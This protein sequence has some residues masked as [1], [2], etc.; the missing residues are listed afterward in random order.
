MKR[1]TVSFGM[2]A[3]AMLLAN[4]AGAQIPEPSGQYSTTAHGSFA[5]CLNPANG[6]AEESCSANNALVYPI[7]ETL[8]GAGTIESGIYCENDY[9]VDADLPPNVTPSTVTLNE[10]AVGKV[11][12]Y[13][14][15]TGIGTGSDT[16][17]TGGSCNGTSF[18]SSGATEVSSSTFQ[19]V[20]SEG[21]KRLDWNITQLTN[22]TNSLGS[23]SYTGTDVTQ[24]K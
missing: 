19:F 14:P 13:D 18:D 1:Y 23:V 11:T 24:T 4:S 6:Y 9:V 12:S 2:L 16:S 5:V 20:V 8:V 10:H 22:P 7:T 21:G 3:L 17:Y 15:A